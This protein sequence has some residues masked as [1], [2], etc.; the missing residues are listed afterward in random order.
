MTVA[1][2]QSDSGGT[3]ESE[4]LWSLK[5]GG[6]F[7]K[8][9][10]FSTCRCHWR[11]Y[12]IT[13]FLIIS[14]NSFVSPI[15]EKSTSITWL[16]VTRYC[17]RQD[18]DNTGNF[19]KFWTHLIGK[20]PHP[21]VH[22]DQ[23]QGLLW[24]CYHVIMWLFFLATRIVWTASNMPTTANGSSAAVRMAP[25]VSGAMNDKNGEPSYWVSVNI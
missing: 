16:I 8:T 6:L 12:S 23:L 5:T 21:F 15:V 3:V 18:Q 19:Y 14:Y 17:T 25:P 24:I 1:R 22:M 20:T 10:P 13:G 7:S 2:I 4:D 9:S 11:K